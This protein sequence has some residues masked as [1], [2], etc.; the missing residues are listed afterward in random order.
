MLV[1]FEPDRL[2]AVRH[3]TIDGVPNRRVL[4]AV[5]HHD[6]PRRLR[7]DGADE[8][9]VVRLGA[10][11]GQDDV[12]RPAAEEPADRFARLIDVVTGGLAGTV[13]ARRV[14]PVVPERREHGLDDGVVRA[15]RRVVVEVDG[16]HA[17]VYA[18]AGVPSV[19][20]GRIIP[21]SRSRKT[22][23]PASMRIAQT[24]KIRCGASPKSGRITT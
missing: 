23:A 5:G 16:I 3:E 17:G 15:G 13:R 8:G 10:A 1:A 22:P 9:E 21:R 19:A 12:A 14:R 2:G 20:I 4:G 7:F 11:R 24:M 18:S 6:A